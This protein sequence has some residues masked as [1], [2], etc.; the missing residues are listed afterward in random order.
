MRGRAGDFQDDGAS[1]RVRRVEQLER[2]MRAAA[3]RNTPTF[4][5]IRAGI[6][7]VAVIALIFVAEIAVVL[8]MAIYDNL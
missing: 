1:F 7:G 6:I 8:G 4:R 5:L 3:Y 2:Q